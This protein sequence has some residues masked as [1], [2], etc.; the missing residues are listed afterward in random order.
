MLLPVVASEMS[1][2]FTLKL[3]GANLAKAAKNGNE[4]MVNLYVRNTKPTEWSSAGHVVAQKQ[5]ELSSRGKLPALKSNSRV[6]GLK[7]ERVRRN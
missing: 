3:S 1:Q 7:V 5:F 2:D 4:V 6:A